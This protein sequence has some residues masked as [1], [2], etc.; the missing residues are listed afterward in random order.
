MTSL[1]HIFKGLCDYEWKALTL[2]LH[3]AMFGDNW[4]AASRDIKYLICR[5]ISRNHVIE[6]S[7]NLMSRSSSLLVTIL[8]SLI[9]TDSGI[10]DIM[11]LVCHII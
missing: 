2:S 11:V 6:G 5:V 3:L 9:A 7:C 4:S 1:D 10:L 8:P